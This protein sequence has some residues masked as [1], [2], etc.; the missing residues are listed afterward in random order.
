MVN[1]IDDETIT[2]DTEGYLDKRKAE[3]TRDA[4]E[5][6]IKGQKVV[7]YDNTTTQDCMYIEYI[8]GTIDKFDKVAKT[9]YTATSGVWADRAT[10][11]YT[12]G[13]I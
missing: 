1:I 4:V 5:K 12:K 11:T 10:L 2:K 8:D 6:A 13:G 9:I 3:I 7:R